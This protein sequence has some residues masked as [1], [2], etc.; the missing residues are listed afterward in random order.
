MRDG[1]AGLG[2]R[3]RRI[4]DDGERVFFIGQIVHCFGIKEKGDRREGLS[5]FVA[6]GPDYALRISFL[7]WLKR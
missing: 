6:H 4:E 7:N 1:L 3:L 2:Q 5:P